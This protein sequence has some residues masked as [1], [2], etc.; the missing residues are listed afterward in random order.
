MLM[1]RSLARLGANI[2][3]DHKPHRAGDKNSDYTVPFPTKL[4][5]QSGGSGIR[6]KG[7]VAEEDRAGDCI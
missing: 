4:L 3:A 2:C 7:T 1:E 6:S 5:F